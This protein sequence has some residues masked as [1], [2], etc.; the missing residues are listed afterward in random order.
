MA[1]NTSSDSAFHL[2]S[3]V[4]LAALIAATVAIYWLGL[5]GLFLFDDYSNLSP[6]GNLDGANNL[7]GC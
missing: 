7:T 2:G 1:I 4:L 5:T 3:G 6:M